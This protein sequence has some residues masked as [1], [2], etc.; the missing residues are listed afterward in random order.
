MIVK[1]ITS[2]IALLVGGWPIFDGIHALATGKY[3]A[4]SSR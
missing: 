1:I 2:L 3:F 4:P